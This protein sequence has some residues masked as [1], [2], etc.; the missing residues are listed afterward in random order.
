M[1]DGEDEDDAA[2]EGGEREWAMWRGTQHLACDGEGQVIDET[3]SQ[4]ALLHGRSDT[5][6]NPDDFPHY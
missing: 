4:T 1:V 2:Q 5:P 6:P 3:F